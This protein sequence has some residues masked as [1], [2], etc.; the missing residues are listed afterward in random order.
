MARRRKGRR[1]KGRRRRGRRRGGRR[2]RN[3]KITYM[4][5]RSGLIMPDQAY[6]KLRYF[7]DATLFDGSGDGFN[8]FSSRL[9]NVVQPVFGE[10]KALGV[11]EWAQ[12]YDRVRCFGSSIRL[13][14]VNITPLSAPVRVSIY[15]SQSNTIPTASA[16]IVA[17]PYSRSIYLNGMGNSGSIRTLSHFMTARKI[18]GRLATDVDYTSSMVGDPGIQLFWNITGDA[19]TGTTLEVK[20]SLR[21]TFYCQLYERVPILTG[22][23]L[24]A[25]PSEKPPL[26]RKNA[27]IM[28]A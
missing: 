7:F 25:K 9:N 3:S 19:L 16:N 8:S 28:A 12:F 10:H 26:E 5:L 23:F 24:T 21:M 13:T 11:A 27:K 14:C 17:Q 2:P 18:V 4:K 20:V 15:P 6:V 22:S 1:R